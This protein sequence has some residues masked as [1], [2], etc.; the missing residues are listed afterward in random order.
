MDEETKYEILL[1]L[2]DE[3]CQNWRLS[4]NSQ[5]SEWVPFPGS[6]RFKT[7]NLFTIEDV[8]RLLTNP[9]LGLRDT[10][11]FRLLSA[12]EN[13]QISVM[14]YRRDWRFR[15]SVNYTKEDL[16]SVKH[17]KKIEKM[18]EMLSIEEIAAVERYMEKRKG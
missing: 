4:K 17:D 2:K 1:Y 11:N 10:N 7:E 9:Y 13:F 18:M 8:D 12:T 5:F 3:D 16:R 14:E 15:K 6:G